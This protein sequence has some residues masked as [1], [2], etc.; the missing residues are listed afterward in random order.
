MRYFYYFW[1]LCGRVRKVLTLSIIF[2]DKIFKRFGSELYRQIVG[3]CM[4][5]NSAPLVAD[6]FCYERDFVLSDIYQVDVAEA[7]NSASRYLDDLLN[8]LECTIRQHL[9]SIQL[10]AWRIQ[11]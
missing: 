9:Y 10:L 6:F 7:L 3:I 11:I 8:P 2:F 1:T 4:G 5:T